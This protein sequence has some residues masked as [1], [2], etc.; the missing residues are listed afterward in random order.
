MKIISK[1]EKING[2]SQLYIYSKNNLKLAALFE[3]NK[4]MRRKAGFVGILVSGLR[5]FK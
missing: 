2:K 4:E 5:E 3:Y 1:E